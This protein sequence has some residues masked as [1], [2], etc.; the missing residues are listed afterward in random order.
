MPDT[1][2]AI[3]NLRQLPYCNRKRKSITLKPIDIPVKG[4]GYRPLSN[5]P[6]EALVRQSDCSGI[7]ERPKGQKRKRAKEQKNKHAAPA[8]SLRRSTMDW[9]NCVIGRGFSIDMRWC[10]DARAVSYLA[11]ETL[12][13][14]VKRVLANI[15]SCSGCFAQC[16]WLMS[17]LI[18]LR[19][20][21][22]LHDILLLFFP[23]LSHTCVSPL[24]GFVN[25]LTY[26]LL[27]PSSQEMAV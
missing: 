7:C 10:F 11:W 15:G 12:S 22:H 27:T 26:V 16:E 17:P 5:Q 13:H 4:Q 25:R 23:C 2:K 14:H 3:Y 24:L 8:S 18:M 19:T 20:A 9:T 6:N 1:L 21:A